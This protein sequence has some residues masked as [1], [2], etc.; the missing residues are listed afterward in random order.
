MFLKKIGQDYSTDEI[1]QQ[2]DH[3]ETLGGTIAQDT[4][5]LAQKM[6]GLDVEKKGDEREERGDRVEDQVE[7][8]DE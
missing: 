3:L 5:W 6:C 4:H 2:F 1:L 8:Q 7:G